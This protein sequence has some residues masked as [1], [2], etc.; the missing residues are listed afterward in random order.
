MSSLITRRRVLTGVVG[1]GA[2]SLGVGGFAVAESYGLQV[3]SYRLSPSNW[4]GGLALRLAVIADLHACDPWMSLDRIRAIVHA[5]NELDA[6]A[7]LLLGDYVVGS[8]LRDYGRKIPH[9]AWAAELAALKAPH[10]VHAVLGNHD[11]WDSDEAQHDM[12]GP[13]PVRVALERVGIPVYE[14]TATRL[15]KNGQG[16]WIAGLGD[17]WAFFLRKHRT[18]RL[19][20][21]RVPR[22]VGVDD[23]PATMAAVSGDDPVILM[24]HEPDI[25]PEVPARV[26]LTISGHTHGGQVRVLGYTPFVPSRYG[27]RYAYGHVVENDRHLVVSGGLGCSSAPVRIGVPPEIVVVDVGT[28]LAA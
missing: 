6:D 3:T 7:I 5:T 28:Q 25:F 4:P 11:W 27:R 19:R 21:G 1:L 14:N 23:L 15:A 22:F 9:E 18:Q 26:S 8:R 10:G 20:E 2:G 12:S 24:A 17:Q 16:F 13:L